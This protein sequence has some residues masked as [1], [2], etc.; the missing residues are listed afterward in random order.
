M[1]LKVVRCC[2]DLFT[3]FKSG[4]CKSFPETSFSRFAICWASEKNADNFG[5]G[6]VDVFHYLSQIMIGLYQENPHSTAR[7]RV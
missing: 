3:A 2:G 4:G 1:P 7:K 6:S 5:A